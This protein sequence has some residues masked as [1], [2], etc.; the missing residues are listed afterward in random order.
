VPGL[1]NARFA[2]RAPSDSS[3]LRPATQT[4]E[5]PKLRVYRSGFERAMQ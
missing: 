5:F 3:V 4:I 1:R 2:P